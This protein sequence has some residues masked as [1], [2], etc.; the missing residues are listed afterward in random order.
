MRT[1]IFRIVVGLVVLVTALGITSCGSKKQ[2]TP[3]PPVAEIGNTIND[4][5]FGSHR[6][7]RLRRRQVTQHRR[8]EEHHHR[9]GPVRLGDHRRG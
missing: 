7:P 6:D 9:E 4:G 2:E 5:T 3:G 8:L 1:N